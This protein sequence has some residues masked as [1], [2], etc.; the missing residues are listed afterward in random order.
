MLT[1]AQPDQLRPG[2]DTRR[3]TVT[4]VGSGV[5]TVTVSGVSIAGVSYIVEPV[6]GDTV[7]IQV[8]GT[9]YLVIGPIGG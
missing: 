5:C 7:H 9:Q 4:A 1:K 8:I 6:N 2:W 3:G